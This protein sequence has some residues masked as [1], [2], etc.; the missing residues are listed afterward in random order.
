MNQKSKEYGRKMWQN[1]W[2]VYN[3]RT[4]WC[5]HAPATTERTQGNIASIAVKRETIVRDTVNNVLLAA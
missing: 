1:Q 4:D 2:A 5:T 3:T